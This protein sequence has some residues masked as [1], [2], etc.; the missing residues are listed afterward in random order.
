MATADY[1]RTAPAQMAADS[2]RVGEIEALLLQKLERW[3][4]LEEKAKAAGG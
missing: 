1:H 4:E 2:T 3:T